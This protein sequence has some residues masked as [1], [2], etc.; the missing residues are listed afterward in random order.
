M[1]NRARLR[2]TGISELRHAV[3]AYGA[4]LVASSVEAVRDAVEDTVLKARFL[5]REKSGKLRASLTGKVSTD[6][7]RVRGTVQ[8]TATDDEGYPYPVLLEFGSQRITKRPF[9]VAPAIRNRQ[10]M[11]RALRA[12][13][14]EHAPAAL[15]T[16]RITGEGPGTPGVST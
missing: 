11:N 4:Q 6:G 5:A 14:L 3:K 15:G 16:P 12:A 13:V 7:Y 2:I 8:A 1:A 9:L 10:R